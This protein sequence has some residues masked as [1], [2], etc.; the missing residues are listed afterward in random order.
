MQLK[1]TTIAVRSALAQAAFDNRERIARQ[2]FEE[3]GQ[4]GRNVMLANAELK[5]RELEQRPAGLVDD[6][7]YDPTGREKAVY[8]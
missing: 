3:I 2:A 1:L 4:M 5:V 8:T 7:H 6:G